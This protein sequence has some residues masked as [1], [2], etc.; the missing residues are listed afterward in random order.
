MAIDESTWTVS[1]SRTFVSVSAKR[2]TSRADFV[3]R[4]RRVFDVLAALL[5][6]PLADR[7]GIRYV[8]RIEEPS[9]L[10]GLARL[11][12]PE[13]AGT[14]TTELGAGSVRQRE[15]VDALYRQSDGTLLQARWGLLEAAVTYDLTIPP[16]PNAAFILD[17]DVSTSVAQ[18]FSPGELAELSRHFAERQY[19]FFRWAVTDDFL[20]AFGGGGHR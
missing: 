6:P 18:P 17:L 15:L 16:S 12:R 3:A 2:Y 14:F 4:L 10:Q 7:L 11:L 20:H 9:L 5:S 8:C 13:V 19:R 1:L